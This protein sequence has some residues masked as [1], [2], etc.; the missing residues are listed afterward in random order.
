MFNYLFVKLVPIAL[1]CISH[2]TEAASCN[3][4]AR[5]KL[6]FTAEWTRESHADFPS[7]AH[8]SHLVG[9]SHN[10]SYVMWTPGKNAT[11][12]VKNVA[13]R[14]REM[15]CLFHMTVTVT[16]CEYVLRTFKVV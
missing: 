10:G 14:G 15:F 4:T 12:G 13:E 6:T 8:F 1:V 9:C 2:T 7:N 11:T 5:Y 3:G 16:S